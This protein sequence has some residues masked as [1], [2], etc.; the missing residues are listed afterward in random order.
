MKQE[1]ERLEYLID[2]HFQNVKDDM[3]WRDVFKYGFEC[4]YTQSQWISVEDKL[5]DVGL[6]VL[7]FNPDAEIK[8]FICFRT[9]N[10]WC[11]QDSDFETYNE[12][13]ITLWQ[14]ITPPTK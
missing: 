5:P 10:H 12:W 9:K 14:P 2:S 8:I 13:N 1:D 11:E 3:E 7:C 4:G 6:E